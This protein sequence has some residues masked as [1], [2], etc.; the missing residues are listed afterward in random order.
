[1]SAVGTRLRLELFVADLDA[2]V[3]FYESVL[4]FATDRRDADGGYASLVRGSARLGLGPI[5]KLPA[6]GPGGGFTQARLAADRGGGTEVVL[7]VDD[8]EAAL[9]RVEA[10][11]H[12]LEAPIQERPWGSRDFRLLDPDGYYLRVTDRPRAPEDPWGAEALDLEAYLHRIGTDAASAPTAEVLRR[13]HRAHV[14]AIPFENLDI[15]LGRGIAV[16]LA[17]VEAK[18]VGRRRGGY[19]YEHGVLFAAALE[20]IGFRVRRLLARIGPERPDPRPR[21]HLVLAVEAEGRTW[22]ADTGFGSGLLEPLPLEAGAEAVQGDWAFRLDRTAAGAWQLSERERGAWAARYHVQDEAQ[23]PADVA[24]AN[25]WSSTA[26]GSP[27]V[28]RAVAVRKDEQTVR[29]LLGRVLSVT[30]ADGTVRERRLD[31]AE[32]SVTLREDFGLDLGD[33]LDVRRFGPPGG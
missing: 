25:H 29:R 18:L 14:A 15:V 22:L 31:D 33:D 30:T 2:S 28:R 9:A 1:V 17:A 5:A 6:D 21:S 4:G 13:V 7:E 20:A 26:P 27:F 10:A 23:H 8:L 11:G 24:M 12:P 19:C 32:L 3:A 16:D